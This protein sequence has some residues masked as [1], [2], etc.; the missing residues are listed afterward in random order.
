MFADNPSHFLHDLDQYEK[1][2][3]PIIFTFLKKGKHKVFDFS[4][5]QPIKGRNNLSNQDLRALQK[6][7]IDLRS[8]IFKKRLKKRVVLS[9]LATLYLAISTF[10]VVLLIT[11]VPKNTFLTIYCIEAVFFLAVPFYFTWAWFKTWNKRKTQ[12]SVDLVARLEYQWNNDQKY[13]KKQLLFSLDCHLQYLEIEILDEDEQENIS[14]SNFSSEDNN[15]EKL[16]KIKQ[17][18][19]RGVKI[20]FDDLR[21]SERMREIRE[22]YEGIGN[23]IDIRQK[24]GII[25]VET[26][27]DP[28]KYRS[29]KFLSEEDSS[30]DGPYQV[31]SNYS[32]TEEPQISI[33]R[34]QRNF[35]VNTDFNIFKKTEGI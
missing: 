27:V 30:D 12:P 5:Y 23:D 34:L 16:E 19:K 8:T 10:V 17:I 4:E 21:D 29:N 35:E 11:L 9:L 20:T 14:E 22:E 15:T 33:A 2:N 32:V 24:K 25:L 31:I 28:K 7:L 3:T 18:F 1:K 6:D 13:R 26:I